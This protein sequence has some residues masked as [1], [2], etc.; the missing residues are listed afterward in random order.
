MLK[1]VKVLIFAATGMIGRGILLE[2]TRTPA[3]ELIVNLGRTPI[4][5]TEGKVR[6]IVH[7]DLL[8]YAGMERVSFRIRRVLLLSRNGFP[9]LPRDRRPSALISRTRKS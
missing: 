9:L 1:H 7:R 8:N 6:D 5:I 2:C 3:V 4:S